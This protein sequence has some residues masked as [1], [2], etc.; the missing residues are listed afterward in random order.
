M[1]AGCV[2]GVDLAAREFHVGR[3]RRFGYLDVHEMMGK[4]RRIHAPRHF[5]RD[6]ELSQVVL[7]YVDRK[8][9]D[10]HAFGLLGQDIGDHAIDDVQVDLV[11]QP[12]LF[13]HGDELRR[14]Q[15]AEHRVV[16]AGERLFPTRTARRCAH[17][18][19]V[20]RLHPAFRDGAVDLLEHVDAQPLALA[21]LVAEPQSVRLPRLAVEVACV[22][23]VVG[24]DLHDVFAFAA[25]VHAGTD[26]QHGAFGR[27][28]E[29]LEQQL[30]FI[31]ESRFGRIRVEMVFGE[32][33]ARLAT[34]VTAQHVGEH[35]QQ[36]VAF[37]APVLRVVR[38]QADKVERDD[39]G[40]LAVQLDGA[41]A[42]ARERSEPRHVGQARQPVDRVA[43]GHLVEEH[44]EHGASAFAFHEHAEVLDVHELAGLGFDAVIDM[45]EVV[46]AL[47]LVPDA[48]F[49]ELHVLVVHE[50]LEGAVHELHEI[51]DRVAFEQV[52]DIAVHVDDF[53]V[54][55]GVIHQNAAGG[56]F[57][58]DQYV[59]S[60]IARARIV[61][62]FPLAYRIRELIW[63]AY[64]T[65]YARDTSRQTRSVTFRFSPVGAH[66]PPAERD[67]SC[68]TGSVTRVWGTIS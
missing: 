20:I 65:P 19:L 26:G 14:R 18:R 2:Q 67:R 41:C 54:A 37:L 53:L 45:V 59:L 63:S 57:A 15:H 22:L 11:Q 50:V 30:E 3:G 47:D 6:V 23:G 56:V 43:L 58:V 40:P 9:H 39:G 60:E 48:L 33:R 25:H 42:E 1:K 21:H 36:V 49:D 44:V 61:H 17:D 7:G 64:C 5:A 55:V 4:A 46:V 66:A 38:F 28:L 24:A 52:D 10:R 32:P 13:E 68:L 29:V 51:A 34:E 12:R 16:P 62:R 35:A 27:A 31:G 8:R